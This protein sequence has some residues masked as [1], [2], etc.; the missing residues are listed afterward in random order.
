MENTEQV[1]PEVKTD[2]ELSETQF[3]FLKSLCDSQTYIM[4]IPSPIESDED[5]LKANHAKGMEEILSL[6]EMGFIEKITDKFDEIKEELV[7]A[8]GRPFEAYIVAESTVRMFTPQA[9]VN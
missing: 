2:K 6:V 4:I 3:K 1:K 5:E 8:G 7:E 9:F